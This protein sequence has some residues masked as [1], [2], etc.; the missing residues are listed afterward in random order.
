MTIVLFDTN[1]LIARELKYYADA[2]IS[3]ITWAEMIAGTP[4][5]DILTVQ[6]FLSN[7]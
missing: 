2:T 3:A 4:P 6:S 1:I 5:V 7:F